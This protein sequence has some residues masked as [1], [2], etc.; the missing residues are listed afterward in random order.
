MAYN[1]MRAS[2]YYMRTSA[3]LIT[4]WSDPRELAIDSTT[5]AGDSEKL[6]FLAD[7]TLRFY[8]SNGNHQSHTIWCV[9]SPDLGVTWSAPWT[10]EFTGFAEPGIDWAQI[11]RV[12]EQEAFR[13]V[14]DLNSSHSPVD[15]P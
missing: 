14:L 2:V 6:F 15:S 5:H 9:D 8:I 13:S 12:T 10:L 1:D 11:V 3:S 4:G 7:G